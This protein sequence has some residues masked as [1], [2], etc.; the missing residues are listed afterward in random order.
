MAGS[1]DNRELSLKNFDKT[2]FRQN[3][4]FYKLYIDCE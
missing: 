4:G 1:V 3:P 2:F